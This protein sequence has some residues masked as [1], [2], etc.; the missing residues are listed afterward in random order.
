MTRSIGEGRTANRRPQA[1]VGS[2]VDRTRRRRSASAT[3]LALLCG[4]FFGQAVADAG[5]LLALPSRAGA[6]ESVYIEAPVAA[7]D[8]I[9]LLFA[10]GDGALHLS[11]AGPAGLRGNFLIRTAR[12][13]PGHGAVAALFDAPSD[14]ADGMSDVFRLDDAHLQDVAAAVAALRQRWPAARV[15]LIGTSRGTV[16]VGSVL[17]RRPTLADAYVL[18]SPVTLPMLDGPGLS[19]MS[20]ARGQARV[21]V[22]SNRRDGCHASPFSGAQALAQANGFDFVAVESTRGGNSFRQDDQCGAHAP[23][24]Y[25]GIETEVLDDIR[26]WLAGG[27]AP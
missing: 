16:S 20:W 19:G 2:A 13:W 1:P 24:G 15:A 12:Y 9:V 6:T 26:S 3:W 17:K 4:V 27:P 8:W 10:G 22:L 18:T 14:H 7:P 21:L 25:L 11:A 5:E 23:H